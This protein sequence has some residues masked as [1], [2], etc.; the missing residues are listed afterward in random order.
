VFAALRRTLWSLFPQLGD[1]AVT[2]RWGGAVGVPRDWYPSVGYDRAQGVA[3][4][5][6]YVGDG[7]STAN[8]AGR[9]L[10]DL[11]LGRD[12]DVT[13]LPWVGHVSPPWE[14]EP[15]RWLGINGA[16]AL[17]AS[18]DRAESAG[19]EPRLRT[20]LAERVFGS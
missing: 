13:R 2:H 18:L 6:G 12:T 16:G 3:W 19:Q 9:T 15:L 14:R 7:V 11:I 10:A 4:A 8:L 20:K 5:G 1:A 17:V